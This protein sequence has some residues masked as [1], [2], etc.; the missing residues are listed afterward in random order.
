MT[1]HLSNVRKTK[2]FFSVV[3]FN[4]NGEEGVVANLPHHLIIFKSSKSAL[5]LKLEDALCAA[6]YVRNAL[7][8]DTKK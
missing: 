5:F 8:L 7:K 4:F 2:Y 3:H 1:T 6:N